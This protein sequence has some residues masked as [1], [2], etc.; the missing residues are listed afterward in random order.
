MQLQQLQINRVAETL[1]RLRLWGTGISR[2]AFEICLSLS[3]TV[4]DSV[5]EILSV[6]AA[7]LLQVSQT[8]WYG[9]STTFPDPT[10][11]PWTELSHARSYHFRY[12][13]KQPVVGWTAD[14]H[15][16]RTN[17]SQAAGWR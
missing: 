1:G 6:L 8:S 17:V 11:S 15:Y 9:E 14:V 10:K 12:A 3:E 16:I 4:Q 7:V 2:K 13:R 5:L